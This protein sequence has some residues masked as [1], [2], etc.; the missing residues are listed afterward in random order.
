MA[1]DSMGDWGCLCV[2]VVWF[3]I[4]WWLLSQGGRGSRC[5]GA[6]A[7]E[8]HVRLVAYIRSFHGEYLSVWLA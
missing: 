6:V 7:V 2:R 3:S 4:Y 5:K 1:F 8:H